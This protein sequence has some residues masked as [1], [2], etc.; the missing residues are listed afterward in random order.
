MDYQQPTLQPTGQPTEPVPVQPVEQASV[1][2]TEQNSSVNMWYIVAL[3]VVIVLVGVTYYVMNSSPTDNSIMDSRASTEQTVTE[4]PVA[5]NTTAD[6]T[7][8][9]DQ[10]LNTPESL[11]ADAAI[12]S[13][14]LQSL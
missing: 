4:T 14:D 12:L 2:A 11:D 10:V 8:D 1:Q 6:I 7:S 5:G 13:G 9:L 3:V